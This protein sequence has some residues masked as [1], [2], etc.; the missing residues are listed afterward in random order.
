MD[1][2]F[3]VISAFLLLLSLLPSS[4][5]RLVDVKA[6]NS[7]LV[8]NLNTKLNYTTIQGAINAPETLDGHTIFV[9]EGVYYE[10]I[11]VNKSLTLTGEN[12]VGTTIDGNDTGILMQ[13]TTDFVNVSG[14]TF[15]NSGHNYTDCGILIETSQ[16]SNINGNILTRNVYGIKLVNSTSNRFT[17]NLATENSVAV[18]LWNSSNN[19][20]SRNEIDSVNNSCVALW[21]NSNNNIIQHNRISHSNCTGIYTNNSD[22]NIIAFNNISS[23]E[24]GIY[25]RESSYNIITGNNITSS[26]MTG[27]ALRNVTDSR[28]Y[29]NTIIQ[30]PYGIYPANIS[31]NVFA[32]NTIAENE[33][34]LCL[35]TCYNNT[36]YD[37]NFIDNTFQVYFYLSVYPGSFWNNSIEGNY[38][39]DYH[40]ADL[41]HDGI[42][43]SAY[44]IT[45]LSTPL[46]LKQ[47]DHCPLMGMFSSFNTS[48]DYH[49][50]V[51]S[52]STVEDFEYFD[53]N[54]T[55]KIHV[56]N[57]TA[58]QILGFIRICIP[59]GLINN[60][61]QVRIDGAEP[62]YVNYTL[63]DNGTYRWLYFS[64]H[65]SRLEIIIVPEFSSFLVLSIFM[66][67]TLLVTVV[68]KKCYHICQR[69]PE[70]Y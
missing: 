14:F 24:G 20:I 57:T 12:M 11:F 37:N 36:F 33:Y 5:V 17:E 4:G 15:R 18:D 16:G 61:Y 1:R 46:E 13:I 56:S 59:H 63:Y 47:F 19:L 50:N 40:Y 45:P 23:N 49:V 38:W 43:E 60:T 52:N 29:G 65:H 66:M 68:Y 35:Q 42:G 25:L 10:H 58:T 9:E 22:N 48:L 62:Y 64:Y 3:V 26:T 28:F 39:S 27:L 30:N 21:Q 44:L 2:R 69:K 6:P 53:S 41:N 34:G 32:G 8:H 67:A 70:A 7:H 31:N 51:I 54:S 55:I